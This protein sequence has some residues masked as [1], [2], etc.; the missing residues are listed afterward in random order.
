VLNGHDHDYERFAPQDPDGD[1]DRVRGITEIV[2]GTGGGE[3]RP[4]GETQP[5]SIVRRGKILGVLKLTLHADGWTWR[6]I[7][8]DGSFGDRGVA[9]CH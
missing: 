6:F 2:A 1:L 3:L 7:S 8:T 5:H 4:M 9:A